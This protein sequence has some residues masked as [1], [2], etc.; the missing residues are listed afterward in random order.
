MVFGLGL[1]AAVHDLHY[2]LQRPSLVARS[3]LAMLVIMPLVAVAIAVLFDLRP[4]VEIALVTLA[5]SPV[6]PLQPAREQK[7]GGEGRYAVGLMAL[8]ALLAI[9]TVPV[10][11]W[12]L[13]LLTGHPYHMPPSTIAGLMLKLMLLP[14]AAGIA[15]RRLA[16][17][18]AQ[19]SHGPL[20]LLATL[21]LV[22]G[23]LAILVQAT[24]AML[25]L[26]G[27][28]TLLAM[29]G[30]IVIGLAI[31]HW[32]GGPRPEHATVLAISTAARHPATALTLARVNVPNEPFLVA[33]LLLYVLVVIAV[34]TIYM[35]RQHLYVVRAKRAA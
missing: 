5:I 18:F 9:V 4:S 2:L 27:S 20:T 15:V 12:L 33:T 35:R 23:S 14:L 24:P 10:S 7:A 34:T 1:R 29:V 25:S 22:L 16:P 8:S 21:F 3:L 26:I 28:G 30:F 31:G 13:G 17:A 32:L 19:R 11:A 6:A